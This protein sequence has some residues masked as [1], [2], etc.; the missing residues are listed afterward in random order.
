MPIVGTRQPMC[1]AVKAW[2]N[3]CINLTATSATLSAAAGTLAAWQSGY[4]AP[5]ERPALELAN[6]VLTGRLMAEAALLRQES[7]GAHYRTDFPQA[8]SNWQHHIVF[9]KGR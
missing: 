2:P 4:Q 5:A 9:K 1:L 8:S 3:S 6:M 7:R